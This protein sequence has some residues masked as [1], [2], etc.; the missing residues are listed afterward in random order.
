MIQA[1]LTIE[2][3]AAAKLPARVVQ[4]LLFS[5]SVNLDTPDNARAAVARASEICG[6]FKVAA[7]AYKEHGINPEIEMAQA[8]KSGAAVEAYRAA[9][10]SKL[11]QWDESAHVDSFLSQVEAPN[12]STIDEMARQFY[13]ERKAKAEAIAVLTA[14]VKTLERKLH[15]R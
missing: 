4:A 13:A 7:S 11:A 2:L 8:V 14:K 6:I 3:A 5:D 10:L 12:V 15:E 1:S 9:V